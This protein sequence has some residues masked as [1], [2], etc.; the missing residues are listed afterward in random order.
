MNIV[1]ILVYLALV[2]LSFLVLYWVIRLAVSHALREHTMN[3][4]TAVNL[5]SAVPLKVA[6]RTSRPRRGFTRRGEWARGASA[7]LTWVRRVR[8]SHRNWD[9]HPPASLHLTMP[10]AVRRSPN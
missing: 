5:P 2:A 10:P 9:C 4:T 6:A 7:R 8:G 1:V 3:S